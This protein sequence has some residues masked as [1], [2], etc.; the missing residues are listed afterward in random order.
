[1]RGVRVVRAAFAGSAAGPE[2]YPKADL[3]EVALAGRSNVGKSTLI[4]ALLNRKGLAKTSSTPGK[5]RLINFFDVDGRFHLVD[6][7]GYGFARVPRG[8]KAAWRHRIEGYITGRKPLRL[9][10]LLLD[11]RHPPADTDRQMVEWLAHHCVPLLLVATKRDKLGRGAAMKAAAALQVELGA[12]VV[13]VSARRREGLTTLW[14]A[15][16]TALFGTQGDGGV[17][18]G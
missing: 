5:T 2:G 8:E 10:V 16:E 9:V 1:L 3:P 15:L 11:I 13:A 12:P 18:T 14:R 6:L 4:N 7:P 17:R